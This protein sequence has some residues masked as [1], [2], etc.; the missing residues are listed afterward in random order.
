MSR[1]LKISASL[2]NEINGIINNNN[3]I[4]S[5][6]VND[7]IYSEIGG[8]ILIRED[9]TYHAEYDMISIEPTPGMLRNAGLPF[10]EVFINNEIADI[11]IPE[12][13]YVLS[14]CRAN[15]SDIIYNTRSD[16]CVFDSP[17]F[18]VTGAT[19]IM[20]G[21]VSGSSGVHII[22]LGGSIDF[23]FEFTANTSSFSGFNADFRY[24]IYQLDSVDDTFKPPPLFVSDIFYYSGFSGTNIVTDTIL[25]SDREGEF[26]IK[27]GFTFPA[28]TSIF[29]NL[30]DIFDT[31]DNSTN[32]P[33]G[34]YDKTKDWYFISIFYPP[35]PQFV[36]G[37]GLGVVGNLIFENLYVGFN[38]Q[39]NF[40]LSHKPAD[41][42][43]IVNLNGVTLL[44]GLEYNIY[45]NNIVF[46][47]PLYITDIVTIY[48]VVGNFTPLIKS[49]SLLVTGIT[50]GATSA[51]TI[52]DKIY[53]N[54]DQNK[55]EY[56]LNTD[57]IPS[58]DIF[59]TVNGLTLSEGVE[60]YPSVTNNKRIIFEIDI[61]TG[62]TIFVVY[63]AINSL[64]GDINTNNPN[65]VWG[66]NP[67]P[68][69]NNGLFT[70]QV[71][72]ELDM[73]FNN[74]LYSATTSY[75]AGQFTYGVNIGPITGGTIGDSYL[76]RIKN[77]RYYTA[78]LSNVITATTY[79][80][81]VKFTIVTNSI[82][83]Y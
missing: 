44:Q 77:D 63:T 10:N 24:E 62:D 18:G 48:Y 25:M 12:R 83:S 35:I 67:A 4:I 74:I 75:V 45:G 3:G 41:N 13:M 28:C 65:T 15:I 17:L 82:N 29:N 50:S 68:L 19:K 56:Y 23:I 64:A 46:N 16:I 79:S 51:V 52:N 40:V 69:N 8:I 54:T 55:Y 21:L 39:T 5:A 38:D 11:I 47:D 30:S 72:D 49:E 60:Y 53:F 58:D 14:D 78:L 71:V 27:G 42:I 7:G 26:L 61:T 76:Y 6:G 31:V 36:L 1:I 70:V 9:D 33:Y 20:T 66:V 57:P 34:M 73:I 80:E 2:I 37:G 81:V 32:F 22:D 43:G 59:V